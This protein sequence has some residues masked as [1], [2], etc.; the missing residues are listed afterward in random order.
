MKEFNGLTRRSLLAG[1][2]PALAI[3]A[4][5]GHAKSAG[6]AARRMAPQHWIDQ[7]QEMADALATGQIPPEQWCSEVEALSAQVDLAGLLA[8]ANQAAE[9][10]TRPAGSND[11]EKRVVHFASMERLSYNAALL[12][13]SPENVI[14]PRAHRNMVSALLV[15][16][17][18]VRIR[19]FE[20]VRDEKNG[21]VI[22]QAGDAAAGAGGICTMCADHHNVHWL[23]PQG[24]PAT[25]LEV[26]IDGLSAQ[27]APYEITPL[28]P[29][30]GKHL[31]DGSIL[32]PIMGFDAAAAKYTAD[33]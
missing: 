16:E 14:T 23:T 28:D 17:G 3:F 7:Q 24:G 1:A 6:A 12:S 8:M 22:K 20:R 29:L 26:A 31:R 21:I 15:V 25:I 18:T 2:M 4:L 32:A 19:T 10:G 11:P 27:G 33:I 9:D 5:L 30:G 13:F